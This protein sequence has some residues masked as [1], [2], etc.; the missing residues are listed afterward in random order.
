MPKFAYKALKD[1]GESYESTARADSKQALYKRLKDK[2]ETLISARP[3][4][5]GKAWYKQDIG[6]LT[7][8]SAEDKILFARNMSAMLDAG[9][10]VTR[11]LGV[12]KRQSDDDHFQEIVT[13]IRSSIQS[14]ES[15]TDGLNN[16]D[17]EF[18]ALFIYMVE[19]GEESG[20]LGEALA[21][22]AD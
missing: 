17:N 15:F 13:E 11:A 1:D 8:L 22:S 21:G 3:A 7:N 9:L 2:G 5:A 16:F 18:S 4:D 19:A 10:S 12:I 14:G 20:S 6:F